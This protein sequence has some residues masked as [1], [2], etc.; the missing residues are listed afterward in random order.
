MFDYA[1]MR[2]L[3]R[4]F[5]EWERA[6]KDLDDKYFDGRYTHSEYIYASLELLVEYLPRDAKLTSVRF[7]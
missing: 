2:N 5:E 1:V 3:V 4:R 7:K 6:Q